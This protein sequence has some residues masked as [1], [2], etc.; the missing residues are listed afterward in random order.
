MRYGPVY[1]GAKEWSDKIQ[2]D[3]YKI[4]KFFSS[5]PLVALAY[6]PVVYEAYLT[7]SK[8]FIVNARGSD[9]A[10]IPTPKAMRGWVIDGM[11]DVD[12]DLVAEYAYKHGYD[13]A[14]VKNVVEPNYPV[15]ADDY[16]VF[17]PSNVKMQGVVEPE[18]DPW[19]ANPFHRRALQRRQKTQES[20]REDDSLT[21]HGSAEAERFIS[22]NAPLRSA[23]AFSWWLGHGNL[24]GI[25][26]NRGGPSF[27]FVQ[28]RD[29]RFYAGDTLLESETAMKRD[30]SEHVDALIGPSP[31]LTE[32]K[33]HNA[34]KGPHRELLRPTRHGGPKKA[35][36][37]LR[38]NFEAV[39]G[40]KPKHR[41]DYSKTKAPNFTSANR[42]KPKAAATV[43]AGAAVGLK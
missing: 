13:G 24:W 34:Q 42:P 1:H 10:S 7:M 11:D 27:V 5:D 18:I 36:G 33:G 37:K 35:K 2:I 26:I 20:F 16:I 30:L 17:S 25:A 6:G 32:K 12:T 3:K 43:T 39:S 29:G 21:F 40:R 15:T 28:K 41:L 38:K 4:G 14:I 22:R 9:Y 31:E 23:S 19:T 8:P